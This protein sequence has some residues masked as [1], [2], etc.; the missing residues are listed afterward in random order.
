[1]NQYREGVKSA[2]IIIICAKNNTLLM[3]FATSTVRVKFP[4]TCNLFV[5]YLRKGDIRYTVI[6]VCLPNVATERISDVTLYA[7]P[8]SLYA[9]S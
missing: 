9:C 3:P 2:N 4:A 8:A 6:T 1:M 7:T 5:Q